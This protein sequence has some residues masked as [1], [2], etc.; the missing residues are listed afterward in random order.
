MRYPDG[1]DMATAAIQGSVTIGPF[2]G[3]T[4]ILNM[5]ISDG[6]TSAAL[7]VMLVGPVVHS[8]L[9]PAITTFRG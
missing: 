9:D 4:G 7:H 1:T 5:E 6:K 3:L 2:D 8:G